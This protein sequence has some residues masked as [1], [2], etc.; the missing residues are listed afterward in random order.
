MTYNKFKFGICDAGIQF[1]AFDLDGNFLG[2][3]VHFYGLQIV[4]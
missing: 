2:T 1:A 4:N 3:E